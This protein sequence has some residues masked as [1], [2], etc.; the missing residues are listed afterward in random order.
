L[1]LCL[2][3]EVGGMAEVADRSLR[4]WGGVAPK[5]AEWSD[6]GGLR[7]DLSARDAHHGIRRS[8]QRRN[9]A[10]PATAA[11]RRRRRYALFEPMGRSYVVMFPCWRI[12]AARL[13]AAGVTAVDDLDRAATDTDRSGAHRLARFSRLRLGPLTP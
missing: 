12:D 2:G 5:G 6:R 11:I 4:R 8:R 13:I 10:R 1:L 9:Y 3:V 7:H